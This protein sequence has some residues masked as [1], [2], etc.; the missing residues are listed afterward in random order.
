M[1]V[2]IAWEREDGD[3][4]HQ[5]TKRLFRCL[6]AVSVGIPQ[7]DMWRLSQDRA[8][9]SRE[10]LE[11]TMASGMEIEAGT[12][13]RQRFIP[14]TFDQDVSSPNDTRELINT[15]GISTEHGGENPCWDFVPINPDDMNWYDNKSFPADERIRKCFRMLGKTTAQPFVE[16]DDWFVD[17][18]SLLP[19]RA[20]TTGQAKPEW[21]FQRK[22]A[23]TSL[24]SDNTM[25]AC[26]GEEDWLEHKESWRLLKDTILTTATIVADRE[27]D[28]VQV[29]DG[30]LPDEQTARATQSTHLPF[31]LDDL[32]TN[33][34]ALASVKHRS[35]LEPESFDA[36]Q[37]RR[38]LKALGRSPGSATA[39]RS[40]KNELK[41]FF[42]FIRADIRLMRYYFQKHSL[43]EI[44][45][46]FGLDA[47][48]EITEKKSLISININKI[49][50]A[51]VGFLEQNPDAVMP[52]I[53][54]KE[55][56][57]RQVREQL[58]SS[59]GGKEKLIRAVL[60]S[61]YLK[62]LTGQA[63]GYCSMGHK[64]EA[65]L[66]RACMREHADESTLTPTRVLKA[67][68]AP[69]VERKTQSYVRDSIDFLGKTVDCLI[70][71]EIKS[72]VS[73]NTEKDAK[74]HLSKLRHLLCDS[75]DPS[76]ATTKYFE[77]DADSGDYRKCNESRSEAIQVLHHAYTYGLSKVLLLVGNKDGAVIYGLFVNFSDN[78]RQKYGELLED[79]YNHTIKSVYETTSN[80][81]FDFFETM[82]PGVLGTLQSQRSDT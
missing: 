33:A 53:Q 59:L 11:Y 52:T 79:I 65:P 18:I 43:V 42:E 66:I 51:I 17:E 69:L 27:A 1:P 3:N 7:L 34:G 16:A 28:C 56:N 68:T 82:D 38:I 74:G 15:R 78:V 57:P 10:Q 72:R 29:D 31:T 80:V 71:V 46:H 75:Q 58:Q 64:L 77:V 40:E 36:S 55:P 45:V 54:T 60:Q 12:T 47:Q 21:F 14:Y 8:Y 48:L 4:T 26:D 20:L 67:Y 50:S 70:G 35:T 44:A 24:T 37:V 39:A 62:P 13:K 32:L 30:S 41:A 9:W 81:P 76:T 22:F 73:V 63:K 25:A 5:V 49:R 19:V 6:D 23:F 2:Q 61:S